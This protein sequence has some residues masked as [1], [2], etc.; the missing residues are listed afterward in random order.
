MFLFIIVQ[1]SLR[2]R[3]II[4]T[5]PA[6]TVPKAMGQRKIGGRFSVNDVVMWVRDSSS[7]DHCTV[8]KSPAR[9]PGRRPSPLSSAINHSYIHI[10]KDRYK[11]TQPDAHPYT[12]P[13]CIIY[14]YF[15]PGLSTMKR[16]CNLHHAV[17]Y[18]CQIFGSH[19]LIDAACVIRK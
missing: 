15:Q 8:A 3:V 14:T 4:Q 10:S 2:S 9:P 11:Q 19:A 13:L 5:A 6:Q 1:S 16:C 7:S 17:Y 18:S 12:S